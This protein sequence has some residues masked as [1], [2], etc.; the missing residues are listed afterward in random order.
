MTKEHETLANALSLRMKELNKH[1]ALTFILVISV[2]ILVWLVTVFIL[3]KPD[4]AVDMVNS[5]IA[6]WFIYR[7]FSLLTY[8]KNSKLTVE[9]PNKSSE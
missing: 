1:V 9:T 8:W 7:Y 4:D 2:S 5:A 6:I 3:K